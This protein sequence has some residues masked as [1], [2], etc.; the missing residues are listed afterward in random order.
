[1]PPK[2]IFMRA[3]WGAC[4]VSLMFAMQS[5]SPSQSTMWLITFLLWWR[6]WSM[7]KVS[8]WPSR[9][10]C[11]LSLIDLSCKH[12]KTLLHAYPCGILHTYFAGIMPMHDSPY[13]DMCL[14]L[15][16]GTN[17]FCRSSNVHVVAHKVTRSPVFS[18]VINGISDS[19]QYSIL[20]SFDLFWCH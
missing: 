16:S 20:H 11:C 5:L 1:M 19:F 15:A 12:R 4:E 13:C 8:K 2:N 9:K 17:F 6:Y 14:S 3:S 7:R 18:P 10:F